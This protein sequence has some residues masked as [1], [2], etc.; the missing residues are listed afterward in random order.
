MVETYCL[1]I[2]QAL[3]IKFELY[4]YFDQVIV[5]CQH[6]LENMRSVFLYFVYRY[7]NM[8]AHCIA[9]SSYSLPDQ[10]FSKGYIPAEWVFTMIG[11]SIAQ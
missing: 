6:L 8:L 11:D 10:I 5:E 7:A 2:I 3:R 9:R 1:V 4:S